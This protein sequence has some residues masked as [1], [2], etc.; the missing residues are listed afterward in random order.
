MKLT[1]LLDHPAL[2]QLRLEMGAEIVPA[3]N[4]GWVPRHLDPE[5][6]RNLGKPVAPKMPQGAGTP[7]AKKLP[8]LAPVPTMYRRRSD[9]KVLDPEPPTDGK[10]WAKTQAEFDAVQALRRSTP[11]PMTLPP[12]APPP[13]RTLKESVESAF[14]A[15]A[16]PEAPPQPPTQATPPLPVTPQV[17][18]TAPAP[19]AETAPAWQNRGGSPP[20]FTSL[21][22][23][24]LVYGGPAPS[25][26]SRSTP[27]AAPGSSTDPAP[28]GSASRPTSPASPTP[29][30]RRN[31]AILDR[32][33]E[34]D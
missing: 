3:P 6:I 16:K 22:S 13:R 23:E 28:S 21:L 29:P 14:A 25:A 33:K 26:T 1:S 11:S 7:P 10:P 27:S 15:Q 30:R 32:L 4:R 31:Q 19:A 34:E 18:E 5:M 24:P 17:T 20:A 9:S 8:A 2:N 12:Q